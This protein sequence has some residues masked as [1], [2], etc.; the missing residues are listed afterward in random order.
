MYVVLLLPYRGIIVYGA[1]AQDDV[2]GEILFKCSGV[3][4]LSEL[5]RRVKCVAGRLLEIPDLVGLESREQAAYQ[6]RKTGQGR[7]RNEEDE[8]ESG[9]LP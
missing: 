3:L 5:F 2:S 8:V 4:S 6:K 1:E 7:K 9:M